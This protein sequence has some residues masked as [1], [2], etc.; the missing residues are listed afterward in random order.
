MHATNN[1]RSEQKNCQRNF[2]F[3]LCNDLFNDF[4]NVH[5]YCHIVGRQFSVGLSYRYCMSYEQRH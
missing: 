5:F 4:I 3:G 1:D 2:I